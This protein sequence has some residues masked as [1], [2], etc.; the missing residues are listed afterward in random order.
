[1]IRIPN[2]S[3]QAMK[4]HSR[5]LYV[6]CGNSIGSRT[7]DYGT[8][9]V[10]TDSVACAIGID[11]LAISV[12]ESKS[13]LLI[14][15]GTS[16]IV[17]SGIVPSSAGNTGNGKVTIGG[18]RHLAMTTS[19]SKYRQWALAFRSIQQATST[20]PTTIEIC[21]LCSTRKPTTVLRAG[22]ILNSPMLPVTPWREDSCFRH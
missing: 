15:D 13:E 21:Q 16:V 18:I 3:S 4:S 1:M 10:P 7:I 2:I 9:S 14:G 22:F 6:A 12:L 17:V 11:D 19:Q 8:C 5:R 20:S